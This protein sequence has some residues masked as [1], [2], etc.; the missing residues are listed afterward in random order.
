MRPRA[1]EVLRS[2]I[3][4]LD[5]EVLPAVAEPYARSLALTVSNLLRHV[6]VRLEREGPVLAEELH[7]LRGSLAEV[8][9]LLREAEGAEIV[10]EIDTVLT[11]TWREPGEHP[12]L[13]GLDGEASALRAVV[14]RTLRALHTGGARPGGDDPRGLALG[15]LRAYLAR[16]LDRE[17]PFVVEAFTGER[18]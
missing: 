8:A 18:R 15:V 6:L 11:R 10:G 3:Q 9:D 16:H 1:D 13:A 12:T 14:D 5:E 4:T 17:M 7:D 2:A